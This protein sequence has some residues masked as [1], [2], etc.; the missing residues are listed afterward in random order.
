MFVKKINQTALAKNPELDKSDLG[1]WAIY[2][3]GSIVYIANSKTRAE[4][5]LKE[6]K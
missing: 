1:R 6:I 3:N 5:V 4:L 2:C